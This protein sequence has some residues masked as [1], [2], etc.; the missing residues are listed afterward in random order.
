MTSSNSFNSPK[1]PPWPSS[2]VNEKILIEFMH[3]PIKFLIKISKEYGD[4][5]HFM[6]GKQHVYLLN[7][8]DY[9][10]DVLIKNYKGLYKK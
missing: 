2:V 8:P 5:I 3:D 6:L 10:E 7:N 1:Y 9:I 4:I